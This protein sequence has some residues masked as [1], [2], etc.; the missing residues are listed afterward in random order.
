MLGPSLAHLCFGMP[1]AKKSNHAVEC[2]PLRGG[3]CKRSRDGRKK[4]IRVSKPCPKCEEMRCAVHCDCGRKGVSRKVAKAERRPG[5]ATRQGRA[6]QQQRQQQQQQ[7]QQ[8]QQQQKQQPPQTLPPPPP[9][10]REL[11]SNPFVQ[12]RAVRFVAPEGAGWQTVARERAVN[13]ILI[14]WDEA[15]TLE[16]IS[17]AGTPMSMPVRVETADARKCCC[18]C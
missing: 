13:Q 3:P 10:R 4:P 12:P 14:D 2:K 1:R 5:H 6:Q 9:P 18:A 17:C 7:L 16:D 8:Q 15:V 11:S